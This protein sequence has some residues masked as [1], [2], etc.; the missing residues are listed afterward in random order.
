VEVIF[1]NEREFLCSIKC[2]KFVD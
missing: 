1:E 2:G